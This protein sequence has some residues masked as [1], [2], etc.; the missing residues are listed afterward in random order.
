[1][2]LLKQESKLRFKFGWLVSARADLV[3]FVL[4]ILAA[5][6]LYSILQNPAIAGSA[7]LSLLILQGLGSGPFHIGN[8]WFQFENKTL[9]DHI[10]GN[11]YR[12]LAVVLGLLTIVL[13]SC[14]G[15]IY[16]PPL[17]TAIFMATSIHHMLRQNAGILRL[18][19]NHGEECVVSKQLEA[20]TLHRATWLYA[21][22]YLARFAPESSWQH[23]PYL[24]AAFSMFIA[25]SLSIKRYI[26][27]LLDQ[28]RTGLPINC[29][30]LLFWGVSLVFFSPLAFLGKDYNQALLI[31]LVMHWFQYIAINWTIAGRRQ[32][33]AERRFPVMAKFIAFSLLTSAL[34]L[35]IGYASVSIISAG[36]LSKVAAGLLIGISF[37]HYLQDACLWKFR[38]PVIR[39]Q[40]LPYLKP[41]SVNESIDSRQPAAER[42][43]CPALR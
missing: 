36:W 13:L 33:A 1:M 40:F 22:L 3:F 31:P 17:I 37:I 38:D 29:S 9:S 18:Y 12:R 43:P 28:A 6:G 16:F 24:I 32:A 30:A 26:T 23:L 7:V 27:D 8:T 15:M 42:E 4:P 2:Q 19:H 20:S 39:K 10:L 21:L 5:A 25:L 35:S 11:G 14:A 41:A 34:I